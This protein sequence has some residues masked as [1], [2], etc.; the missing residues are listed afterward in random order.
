[1]KRLVRRDDAAFFT[2]MP[3]R[4]GRTMA[5]SGLDA[6]W[7]Q[8][9]FLLPRRRDRCQQVPPDLLYDFLH[10]FEDLEGGATLTTQHFAQ[11]IAA[12]QQ[13]ARSTRPQCDRLAVA[14]LPSRNEIERLCLQQKPGKAA[15]PV[16]LAP[17]VLPSLR[18]RL[19][20]TSLHTLILKGFLVGQ[21]PLSY[22]R[23]ALQPIW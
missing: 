17:D 16:A 7:R 11:E 14:E 22:K 19:S 3:E 8:L 2:D 21:E 13:A 20:H 23:G 15:G 5:Q 12:D 6:L 10:H 1:M 4:A 9:H 18:R